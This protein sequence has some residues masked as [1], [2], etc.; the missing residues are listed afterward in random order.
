[1]EILGNINTS[2]K[3]FILKDDSSIEWVP[4]LNLAKKLV[5]DSNNVTWYNKPIRCTNEEVIKGIDGKLYI[6]SH[7]PALSQKE[8]LYPDLYKNL[9]N[10]SLKYLESQ[11]QVFLNSL[12]FKSF[13]EAISWKESSIEEY[14]SNA[15]KCIKVRDLFYNYHLNFFKENSLD[16]VKSNDME[17]LKSLFKLYIE[18]FPKDVSN[19]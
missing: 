9:L 3:F 17:F 12:N 8:F 13:E 18:G 14:K 11:S 16:V 4:S 2:N 15:L 7:M 6:K 1:M 19:L 5:S 10:E